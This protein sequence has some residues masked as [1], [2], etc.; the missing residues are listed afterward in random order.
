MTEPNLANLLVEFNQQLSGKIEAPRDTG[1][2]LIAHVL[3]KPKTWV[4][5][6]PEHQPTLQEVQRI[7]TL[8]DHLLT[9]E[10][11]PYVLGSQEFFGLQF[12]VTPQVLIPRPETELLVEIALA[13]L[14]A[15]PSQRLGAD[16]GTGSGCIAVALATQV[17][18]LRLVA[19]D[20]SQPSLLIASLN[21]MANHVAPQINLVQ[22]DLLAPFAC[23]FD[24]I[25]ANLPYIPSAKLAV[26]N[27]FGFEPNTALDGGSDGLRFIA[28]LLTQT[29]TRINT[30]GLIL[31]EIEATIGQ[32]AIKLVSKVFP[33]GIVQLIPDLSGKD[34]VVSIALQ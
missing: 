24:L 3:H 16:V 29:I 19:S 13:W 4:M 17:P 15:H 18:D 28:R 12:Q 11:L 2:L 34:R 8:C 31:L 23:H 14:H 5:A 21:A 10:P 1:L 6:Y 9:G 33:R 22:A 20:I 25:I 26:V 27:T 7:T 30:P 32:A